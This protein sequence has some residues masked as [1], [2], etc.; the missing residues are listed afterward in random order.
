L[1]RY[2]SAAPTA[3]DE[4]VYVDSDSDELKVY[5]GAS[6]TWV[7][8]AGAG[9]TGDITAVNTG[10]GLSGGGTSGDVTLSLDESYS[11]TWT[12]IHTFSANV[13]VGAGVTID[14]VDISAH[15][16]SGSAHHSRY[17][18]GEARGAIGNI[19]GSDGHADAN[20]DMDA[21]QLLDVGGL[22]VD[23]TITVY[24]SSGHAHYIEPAGSGD[25]IAIRTSSNGDEIFQVRSSGQAVRFAVYHNNKTYV[26]DDLEVSADAAIGGTLTVNGSISVTG[27]VDG[28]DLGAHAGDASAHH[29]RYTDSEARGAIGNIFGSDGHADADILLD[30]HNLENIHHI[31]V[32]SATGMPA[33]ALD[34]R[35]DEYNWAVSVE[36]VGGNQLGMRMHIGDYYP[37]ESFFRMYGGRG[38]VG[39]IVGDGSGG[40]NYNSSSDR[41]SKDVLGDMKTEEATLALRSVTPIEYRGKGQSEESQSRHGFA[42]QDLVEVTKGV[43]AYNNEDDIYSMDYSRLTPYLWAGWKYHQATIE[44]LITRVSDLEAQATA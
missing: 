23:G 43:V 42:A 34:I 36:N 14:G 44:D 16:A 17:T 24:D 30:S 22:A 6:S 4:V 28:V 31:G 5:D 35:I 12:G 9:G 1:I 2:Q 20:I 29:S 37:D 33:Y 26:G 18:D 21:H 11:P 15:A 32:G 8:V 25:G 3:A 38:Q 40:V 41:R 39:E 13:S 10:N 19:F 7:T 27:T